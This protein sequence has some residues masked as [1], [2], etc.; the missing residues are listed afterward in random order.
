[1]PRGPGGRP[2][3]QDNYSYSNNSD[4]TTSYWE[5]LFGGVSNL[6]DN[7]TDPDNYEMPDDETMDDF[8]S[9]P[10]DSGENAQTPD[11]WGG[12]VSNDADNEISNSIDG[13][14]R[15][16]SADE[17]HDI[18]QDWEHVDPTD[19]DNEIADYL[20]GQTGP[21]LQGQ[22]EKGPDGLTEYQRNLP[23]MADYMD[24]T[25]LGTL[26]NYMD[27]NVGTFDNYLKD[28]GI[29]SLED[30][31]GEVDPL[32]TYLKNYMSE[33]IDTGWDY[34][35]GQGEKR[36]MET[37]GQYGGSASAGFGG[38]HQAGLGRY[39]GENTAEKFRSLAPYAQ[40]QWGA[41]YNTK[42]KDYMLDYNTQAGDFDR[43]YNEGRMGYG[44]LYGQN[45]TD[46]GR[47]A[48]AYDM[49]YKN[50]SMWFP[51][52]QGNN[53]PSRHNPGQGNQGPGTWETMGTFAG[54]GIGG[55]LSGT[56]WGAA[57]GGGLGGTVG[58][59]FD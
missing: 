4:E 13:D 25:G 15:P 32:S 54:L 41:D 56:P 14:N 3:S 48:T 40:E 50:A 29:G 11:P 22:F 33:N 55:A 17:P 52:A 7:I 16:G 35:A 28:S 43:I 24:Q 51:S 21:Y 20:W 19:S 38:Q 42:G 47:K 44:N 45:I 31:M 10:D 53:D 8:Y 23:G 36:L 12:W 59:W 6:W 49:P 46:F 27:K 58:G 34:M 30:R 18:P 26:Q 1:M 9:D 39:W 2:G 5:S 37:M 57:I